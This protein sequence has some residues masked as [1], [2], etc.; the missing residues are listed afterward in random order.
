M[1][2]NRQQTFQKAHAEYEAWEN[3]LDGVAYWLG[4]LP[5]LEPVEEVIIKTVHK[6]PIQ[7][8]E[9]VY[10]KC[11]FISSDSDC[12][13]AC[14]FP[15]AKRPCLLILDQNQPDE[16][17]IAHQIA[18]A[19]LRHRNQAGSQ[20]YRETQGDEEAACDLMRK[21]GFSGFGTETAWQKQ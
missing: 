18:C 12:G 10:G 5:G 21:W 16:E 6:L 9:F 17:D 19:W 8:R 14:C 15:T 1:T 13:Q 3:S 4:D 2:N 20:R 7:I 11:R